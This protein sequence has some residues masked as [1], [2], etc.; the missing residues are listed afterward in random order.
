MGVWSHSLPRL[1][2]LFSSPTKTS[3]PPPEHRGY[4]CT[5][6]LQTGPTQNCI[7]HVATSPVPDG[8]FKTVVNNASFDTS[9]ADDFDIFVEEDGDAYIVYDQDLASLRVRKLTPNY[10]AFDIND[11]HSK[12]VDGQYEAPSIFKRGDTY[13]FMYGWIVC[14]GKRGA[15]VSVKTSSTIM[16]PYSSAYDIGCRG[17]TYDANAPCYGTLLAQQAWVTKVTCAKTGEDQ[18]L[19]V[20]DQWL[21]DPA[22]RFGGSRQ[23]WVP[24]AFDDSV[25]PPVVQ[26][27]VAAVD[28]DKGIAA[29]ILVKDG[30]LVT[31]CGVD[32]AP[33]PCIKAAVKEILRPGGG[34]EAGAECLL[35]F[36]SLDAKVK[37]RVKS[38]VSA[39]PLV[40]KELA[41]C[42]AGV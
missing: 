33:V 12:L 8:P 11:P 10:L 26:K 19:W 21:T 25:S 5:N 32:P 36:C 35:N 31:A 27:Q 16:G 20:G 2:H 18:F 17:D 42:V 37:G 38:C 30:C 34:L 40:P 1:A 3:L 28:P 7:Y 24:L 22:K 15:G 9:N 13:Y 6:T 41:S 23:A 39:K 4:H 14:F 29:D